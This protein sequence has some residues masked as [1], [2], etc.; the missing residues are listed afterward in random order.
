MSINYFNLMI[1]NAQDYADSESQ[2]N[3]TYPFL[4][5]Q[6]ARIRGFSEN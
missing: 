1:Y 6:D 5:A 2:K 3:F 4:E